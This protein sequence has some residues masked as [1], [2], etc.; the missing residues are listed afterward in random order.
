MPTF[1]SVVNLIDMRLGFCDEFVTNDLDS[2]QKKT[3]IVL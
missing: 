3:T 2:S 1:Y